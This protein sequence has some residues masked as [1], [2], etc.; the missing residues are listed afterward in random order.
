MVPVRQ[1]IPRCHSYS[2]NQLCRVCNARR[3][4]CRLAAALG[5]GGGIVPIFE[6]AST[7]SPNQGK[8]GKYSLFTQ[9]HRFPGKDQRAQE[10]ADKDAD[11]DVPVEVHGKQHDKISHSELEHVHE[12]ANDML[13]D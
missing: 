5:D 6:N 1:F 4:V 13:H 7:Y 9:R 3:G 2:V 12:R 10:S 8:A 11:D